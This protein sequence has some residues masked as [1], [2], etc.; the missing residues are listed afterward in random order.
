MPWSAQCRSSIKSS[1]PLSFGQGLQEAGHIVEQAQALLARGRAGF[2]GS[3]PSLLSIS[4]ASLASSLAVSPISA[5]MASRA[6]GE[7]IHGMPP[8]T[9]GKG[10]SL[11]IHSSR[12]A[13]SPRH[14]AGRKRPARSPGGFSRCRAR[15]RSG[16]GAHA[17]AATRAHK[18]A[19]LVDLAPPSDHPAAGELVEQ[20]EGAGRP[21][22]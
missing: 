8:R 19:Q 22:W 20:L 10:W 17:L 16:P 14:P 18:L 6:A 21:G 15:R 5:W 2:G 11:R 4:G 9:A 1:S 12:R 13:G 3:G 7:P